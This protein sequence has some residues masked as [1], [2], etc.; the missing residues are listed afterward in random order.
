MGQKH[1]VRLEPVGI[2]FEVDEDETVINGAFR[3]GLMLMHGCKEGQCGACKSFVLDGEVDLDPKKMW[4]LDDIRGHTLQ[5]PNILLNEMTPE[6][7]EKH[8]AHYKA[9]GPGGRPAPQPAAA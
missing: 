7:R 6:E 3:Q 9:G 5:S 8:V 2:D 1:A 4:T